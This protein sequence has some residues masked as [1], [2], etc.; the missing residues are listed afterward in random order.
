VTMLG[1]IRYALR[2]FAK[3]PSFAISAVAILALGIAVNT[4]AFSL[5]K[6]PRSG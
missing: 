4:V 3:W 6:A 5:L 2:T 1:D